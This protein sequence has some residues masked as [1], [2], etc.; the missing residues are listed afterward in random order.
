MTTALRTVASREVATLF[1]DGQA[2]AVQS[3]GPAINATPD[4]D[5]RLAGRGAVIGGTIG[6]VLMGAAVFVLGITSAMGFV[7]SIGIG[8]FCAFWGGL[9][10]GGMMGATISLI[11]GQERAEA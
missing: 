4:Y 11:K 7:S 1:A 3:V 8:L 2:L 5:D 6:F 10:F 9:G